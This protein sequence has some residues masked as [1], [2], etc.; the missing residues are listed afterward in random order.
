MKSFCTLVVLGL[1][2]SSASAA[3]I[4]RSSLASIGLPGFVKMSQADAM[5]C[6]RQVLHHRRLR[7]CRR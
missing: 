4:P 3:D 1:L 2:A 7:Q 6:S 5:T